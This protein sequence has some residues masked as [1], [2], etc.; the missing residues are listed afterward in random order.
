M[1]NLVDWHAR[2]QMLR[3]DGRAF[4]NGQRMAAQSGETLG[5][6]S[7]IDGRILTQVARGSSVDVD[8]AVAAARRSFDDRRWAGQPPSARKKVLQ[9]FAQK[10]VAAQ[11]ELALLETLDVGKPIQQSLNFD[12]QATAR[13]MAWYGE[14]IDK[15]YDEIAP[16]GSQALA[17]ITREPMGVIGAVVPWNYPLLMAAWKLCSSRAKNHLLPPCAWLSWRWMRVYPRVC[18][19]WFLAGGMKRVRLWLCTRM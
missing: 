11:E 1:N 8:A 5:C 18:S 14:A 16:T 12:V 15:I 2:A 4:I 3:F 10:I 19:M 9:N 13:C 17:L 6:M 7:P